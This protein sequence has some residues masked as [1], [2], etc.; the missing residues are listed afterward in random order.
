VENAENK[1]HEAEKR[2]K[3]NGDT[4]IKYWKFDNV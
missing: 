4:R 2:Y 1:N 3:I